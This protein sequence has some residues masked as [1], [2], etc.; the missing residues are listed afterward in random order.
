MNTGSGV[1]L[2]P[3]R[4]QGEGGCPPVKGRSPVLIELDSISALFDTPQMVAA[5]TLGISLTTL[6]QVCRKLGVTRWPYMRTARKRLLARHVSGVDIEE[7]GD[8][9]ADGSTSESDDTSCS[10]STS[11]TAC[12]V[13]ECASDNSEDE[14]TC[15]P[16]A[17]APASYLDTHAPPPCQ[18]DDLTTD[19]LAWLVG[20][21]AD[22][23]HIKPEDLWW[24]G[25]EYPLH[26]RPQGAYEKMHA[27]VFVSSGFQAFHSQVW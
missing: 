18:D 5:R 7:F 21:Y 11:S 23:T 2:F 4:K 9:S 20:G 3:R 19:D 8:D 1:Q 22:A 25:V 6:K 27:N 26:A 13:K 12:T 15:T 10:Q 24:H 14:V 17:H 16:A